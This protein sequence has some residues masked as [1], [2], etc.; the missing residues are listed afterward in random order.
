MKYWLALALTVLICGAARAEDLD[1]RLAQGR[2]HAWSGDFQ[3][4]EDDILHVT[5]QNPKYADAWSAL[6]DVY[7]W[8]KRAEKSLEAYSKQI[9]L[10]P[11]KPSGLVSRSKALRD[12]RRFPQARQDLYR[13]LELGGDK[14][15]I[16]KLLRDLSRVPSPKAWESSFAYDYQSFSSERQEWQAFTAYLKREHRRGSSQL[17]AAYTKRF[18]MRDRSLASDNY[19]DLWK[20]S[21]ANVRYQGSFEANFLPKHDAYAEIFQGFGKGWEASVSYRFSDFLSD[22]VDQGGL[23][24][25]RYVSRFYVREKTV[26][27]PDSAGGGYSQQF[28]ARVYGNAVDDF[29]ELS[30]GFGKDNQVMPAVPDV[31]GRSS[32]FCAARVQKFFTDALGLSI[33]ADYEA[34]EKIP[35][36]RG[37]TARILARW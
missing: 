30:G 16:G 11:Q 35:S 31:Q 2:K 3:K 18:S 13:A 10:E 34:H 19:L 6:G 8:S 24:L 36:Q 1:A 15:E 20:R 22:R 17:E 7:L 9:E 14:A 4:A 27:I 26:L 12:L 23:S 32:S 29:F 21:Y 5:R 28:L 37:L 33:S 25:A